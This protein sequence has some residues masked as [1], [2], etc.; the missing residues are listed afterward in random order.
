MAE[1]V[2]SALWAQ[3]GG[4]MMSPVD[5]ASQCMMSQTQ[6]GWGQRHCKLAEHPV[7]LVIPL[8]GGCVL[9]VDRSMSKAKKGAGLLV[10]K[11]MMGSPQCMFSE[12]VIT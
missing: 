2:V 11:T 7:C 1:P 4:K 8:P 10:P 12:D 3:A 9:L 5:T 6:E